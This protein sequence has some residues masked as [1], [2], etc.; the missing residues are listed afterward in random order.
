MA[1][2][3]LPKSTWKDC[4]AGLP[5]LP[6]RS[7]HENEEE[8]QKLLASA[9]LD[10]GIAS[11]G[12]GTR[13][14]NALD[15]ANVLSVRD[16]LRF[17]R[18]KLERMRG[19]GNK[20]RREITA[21]VRMLRTRLLPTD[22]TSPATEIEET[23]DTVV[24]PAALPTSVEGM[25][26][27]VLAT[28]AK[29]ARADTTRR[30]LE[31][32]L[33]RQSPLTDPWPTQSELAGAV[34]V[35]RARV[36]QIFGKLL[37]AA[38]RDN[39]VSG[40]REEPKSSLHEEPK[41]GLRAELVAI[42]AA[43]GGV[44]TAPELAAMFCET[45]AADTTG[46]ATVRDALGIIRIAVDTEMLQESPR[47]TP[48][49]RDGETMFIAT[50]TALAEYALR[51]G[52][53]ADSLAQVEPLASP[54]H[55]LEDLR[56][57]KKPERLLP[58]PLSDARLVRLAAAASKQACVSSRQELYPRG[59][60]PL[61][62][63]KLSLGAVSGVDQLT[64]ADIGTRVMS[65]YPDASPLPPRPA[66]DDL[67]RSAGLDLR[68]DAGSYRQPQAA[69][70]SNSRNVTSASSIP[71][72][73]P[74]AGSSQLPL[75][76]ATPSQAAAKQF[77]SRLHNALKQGSFLQLV[78]TPRDYDRTAEEFCNRF[79]V[80][81]IDVEEVVLECLQATAKQ[82][83]V[84]WKLVL[85]TDA[86]PGGSEWPRLLQLVGRA[87]PAILDRLCLA[88]QTPLL[89]YSD[90][91][92]RYQLK[93]LLLELHKRIGLPGGPSGI[94]LLV[95]GRDVPLIASEPIGVPGQQAAVPEAWVRNEH[96]TALGTT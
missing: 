27:Y 23:R 24:E 39:L 36:G 33:G 96:R 68:Y 18:S 1:A 76:P 28:F 60:D 49:R 12:L 21:A 92:V 10:T 34:D 82:L 26:D 46:P 59:M 58:Q 3:I 25:S 42:V 75:V 2:V 88:E 47:L 41:S 90:I 55:V 7:D 48:L 72:R 56:Q 6:L 30:V 13:A 38:A 87:R 62:A 15:R 80:T 64:E 22:A 35:T 86:A 77:E 44:M 11:L 50:E 85:A 69:Q 95:P 78:V 31:L 63:L 29:S 51:L 17:N 79:P 65:R 57:E 83:G 74:T 54:A 89:V 43:H 40:L 4:F 53:R 94:W 32:I 37:A 9:T 45:H 16:L 66:L 8:L 81:R 5:T 84:D 93:S 71:Q 67:L 70:A 20:T 73:F 19:V 91:L 52:R 61:R 14:T